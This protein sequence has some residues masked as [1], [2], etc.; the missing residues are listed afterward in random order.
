VGRSTDRQV[1]NDQTFAARFG[2]HELAVKNYVSKK[3][4]EEVP[5]LSRRLS[6]GL[7]ATVGT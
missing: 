2:A 5:A 3:R 6:S 7:G 1:W 4:V